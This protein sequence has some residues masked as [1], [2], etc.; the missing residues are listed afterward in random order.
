[1]TRLSVNLGGSFEKFKRPTI[2]EWMTSF[3]LK[4]EGLNITHAYYD[5][6]KQEL[7]SFNKEYEHELDG[8]QASISPIDFSSFI[9]CGHVSILFNRL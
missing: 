4:Y 9:K 3:K 8:W 1:M 5:L 2:F 6:M 7:T